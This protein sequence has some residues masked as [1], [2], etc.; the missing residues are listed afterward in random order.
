MKSINTFSINF[1]IRLKKKDKSLALLFARLLVN[2]ERSE[3]SL[4]ETIKTVEWDAPR[5][6][7]RGKSPQAKAINKY[8]EDVRFRV[9]EKYRML[10]EKNLTITANSVKEAYLGIVESQNNGHKLIE[11]FDYHLEIFR[12]DLRDG[13]LKNYKTTKEYVIRFLKA[14]FKTEDI[15][16]KELDYQFI[17]E[18]KAFIRDN[19]IKRHD[20]CF[21][22]GL[23]KHLERMKKLSH[24]AKK[25]KWLKSD[26]FEELELTFKKSKR[27]RL[28]IFELRKI[29]NKNFED[30]KLS[31]V[32]HL[33]LFSCYT[34][35]S[36]AEVMS[37][38]PECF[39]H[40]FGRKSMLKIYR[41][42]TGELCSIPLLNP[43]QMIIS[44][45][46]NEPKAI[47]AGTI[48]APIS[49]QDVNR[50]LKII[51]EVCEISK[52]MTFHLAR[53]TFATVVTLKNGVP[54]ETIS[55][56]LGHTKISTTKIYAEV[57]DQKIKNDMARVESKF[58]Y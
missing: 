41:E 13:T 54:I 7:L 12:S 20:P 8:I 52:R 16:L 14:K 38:K 49:N 5:E 19:P 45:Y 35:L 10:E 48:F 39:Q 42:K 24:W 51:Q 32:K 23:M 27:K 33:F 46:E 58:N 31:Y 56:M 28:D 2:G 29:E 25:L 43:A 37:L 3:I 57:D 50:N 15:F 11:L 26:P 4:K 47:M 22:N 55:K 40:D 1:I 53:H 6:M 21:G 30:S 18:L 17:I 9:K 34:G 44:K 36:Y